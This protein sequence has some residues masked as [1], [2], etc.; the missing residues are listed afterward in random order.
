MN[1]LLNQYQIS[2]QF[3]DVSG[4]EYLDLLSIRDELAISTLTEEDQKIM[5]ESDQILIKNSVLIYQ[6]LS[7]FINLTKYRQTNKI[8]PQQWWWY[9]DVVSYLPA[10]LLTVKQKTYPEIA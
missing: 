9:L 1:Q 10:K 4:A 3:L 8:N 5:E 7:R 2:L 6:E